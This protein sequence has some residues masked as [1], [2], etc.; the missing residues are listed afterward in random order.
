MEKGCNP[1]SPNFAILVLTYKCNNRCRWCYASPAGFS[2]REISLGKAKN[3]LN[4]LKKLKDELPV[5]ENEHGIPSL[6]YMPL[7]STESFFD[8]FG[9]YD[10]KYADKFK[11]QIF[12]NMKHSFYKHLCVPK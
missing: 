7:V 11:W 9:F 6:W 4:L 3:V 10:K 8:G 2:L 5:K 1:V 12:R